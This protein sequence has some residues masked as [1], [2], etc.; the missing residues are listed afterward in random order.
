M[1][2]ALQHKPSTRMLTLY[3]PFTGE[4]IEV[5]DEVEVESFD[6]IY[7]GRGGLEIEEGATE[8]PVDVCLSCVDELMSQYEHPGA[9]YMREIA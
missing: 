9:P 7:C 6:C 1:S 2:N 3:K 8:H 5:F 4:P